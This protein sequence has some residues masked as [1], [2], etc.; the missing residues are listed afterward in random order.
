MSTNTLLFALAMSGWL[1]F[2]FAVWYGHHEVVNT[3]DLT[4]SQLEFQAKELGENCRS[5]IEFYKSL[6]GW[7]E[8]RPDN[9]R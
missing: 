4:N 5:Q 8:K 3:F 7:N 1:A 6:Y 2:G 9:G